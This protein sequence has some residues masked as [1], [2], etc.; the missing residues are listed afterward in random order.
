MEHHPDRPRRDCSEGVLIARYQLGA[1]IGAGGMAEVFRAAVTGAEGF[2]RDVAIK[3]VL[4]GLSDAGQFGAMFVTEAR[5]ASQLS[6]AN[7]VHVIDRDATEAVRQFAVAR[8]L[9]N[10]LRCGDQTGPTQEHFAQDDGGVKP[11]GKILLQTAYGEAA[12]DEFRHPPVRQER[13]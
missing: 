12:A 6:H 8:K 4:P 5:I 9:P 13:H 7:I 3:R 1:R 11:D 2:A 10:H